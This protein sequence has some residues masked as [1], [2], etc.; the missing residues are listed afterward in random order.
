MSADEASAFQKMSMAGGKSAEQ[1]L[2][3]IKTSVE[4][5]TGGM[6]NYKD[7]AKDIA[8]FEE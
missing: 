5:M 6:M 8:V 1:N 2:A 4:S 7:V 3:V